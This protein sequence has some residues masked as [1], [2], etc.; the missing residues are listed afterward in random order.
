MD[1]DQYLFEIL[2]RETVDSSL[3][4]PVRAVQATLL[5][6]IS[7]WAGLALQSIKPSGSFAKGTANHSS[8]DIDL[9]ISLSTPTSLREIYE[10]LYKK[11]RPYGAKKQNVSIN[12]RVGD[13]DVDLVPARLL[14]NDNS[15][16]HSLYRQR[17]DTWTKTNV[18]T[19]IATVRAAGFLAESR[20]LKLW[21]DQHRLDCPSFYLE[22][23]VI[24]AL[25]GQRRPGGPY[26]YGS[27]S[28]NVMAVFDYMQRRFAVARV[29]DPANTNNILSDDVTDSEKAK[30]R[31]AANQ[32]FIASD[33]RYVVQ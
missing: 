6:T 9:F 14:Q 7:E 16:D 12:V 2:E 3:Y 26:Q 20:I 28:S 25:V 18:D 8:T 11:M 21:R 17:A 15:Q 24:E 4:S 10:T 27:L 5:P 13:Y 22:M 32:A 29:V 19:H 33:W 1:A 30:I 31:S 23:T